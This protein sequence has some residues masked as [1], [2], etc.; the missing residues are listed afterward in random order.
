MCFADLTALRKTLCVLGPTGLMR[1]AAGSTTPAP[2][3]PRTERGNQCDQLGG[4]AGAKISLVQHHHGEG[5]RDK[6][7]GEGGRRLCMLRGE[8]GAALWRKAYCL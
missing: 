5:A 7:D 1:A 2:A 3:N 4:R 6:G 8:I